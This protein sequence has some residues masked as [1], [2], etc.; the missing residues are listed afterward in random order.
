[1][2]KINSRRPKK[3]CTIFFLKKKKK[4]S[5]FS[6]SALFQ[7]KTTKAL[8]IYIF[9]LL[10]IKHA[11]P[12]EIVE[13]LSDGYSFICQIVTTYFKPASFIRAGTIHRFTY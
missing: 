1:M 3:H 11:E 2:D 4:N 9:F 6:S 12:A 7:N 8:Q 13:Y 5:L 10:I